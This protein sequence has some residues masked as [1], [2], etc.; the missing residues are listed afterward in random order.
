MILFMQAVWVWGSGED[1]RFKHLANADGLSQGA[2]T[3]MIQDRKGFMWFG[4]Q[5]GLN[6]YDGYKFK[7][8]IR[9]LGEKNTISDNYIWCLFEDKEGY[10]W[11]GTKS[12]GLNRFDPATETFHDFKHDPQVATS[13][14]NNEVLTI[15]IDFLGSIWIGMRDGVVDK[16]N[17]KTGGFEHYRIPIPNSSEKKEDINFVYKIYE[18]MD[19]VLWIGTEKG[20]YTFDGNSKLIVPKFPET[21]NNKRINTIL[22]DRGG[23][24]WIGTNDDGLYQWR[25]ES[26]DF[27]EYR[28]TSPKPYR[29][30][31]KTIKCIFQ[32]KNGTL[33][34]GTQEGLHRLNPTTSNIELYKHNPDYNYSLGNNDILSIY[35]DNAGLMWFGTYG[36]GVSIYDRDFQRFKLYNTKSNP[37]TGLHNNMVFS[38][39]EN[40]EGILWIGTYRGGLTK[41]DRKKGKNAH[42]LEGK[43]VRCFWEDSNGVLWL[44]TYGDGVII[45][46]PKTGKTVKQ[47]QIKDGL[48]HD[49]VLTIYESTSRVIWMA[50]Y[51]G[52]LNRFNPNGDQLFTSYRHDSKDPESLS[53]DNVRG[54]AEDD[55]GYIWVGT[56]GGGLNRLDIKTGKFKRFMSD[57]N[58]KDSLTSNRTM[59]INIDLKKNF[60][61][62]TDSGGLNR[63]V[64]EENKRFEAFG[65]KNGLPNDAIYSIL[66]DTQGNIW[67]S[68]DKGL[69]RFNLETKT[70]KN[71]DIGD[72]LQGNEFNIGAYFKSDSGE[73]FFGGLNGVSA[74]FP[75]EIKDDPFIPPVMITDFFLLNKSVEITQGKTPLNKSILETEEITLDYEQNMFSFEFAALSY[76]NP[77]KNR[78]KYK[79]DGYD[80]NWIETDAM[81][82]RA[83]YT[84]LPAGI[85]TFMV[86]GSNKDGV[87]N[88]SPKSIKIEVLPPPWKT[89]WA[90]TLYGLAVVLILAV[91]MWSQ[92]RKVVVEKKLSSELDQKV[93]DRTLE[94]N[95]K[96]EALE[97]INQIVRSINT[98]T[99]FVDLLQAV[100]REARI[101]KGVERSAILV[102][103]AEKG[104]FRPEIAMGWDFELLRNV[105]LKKEDAKNRYEVGTEEIYEDIFVAKGVPERA[106][107]DIISSQ[108]NELPKSMLITCIRTDNISQAYFVFSNM[109]DENAFDD[110]DI[111]LLKNLK[112]HIVA[113]FQKT[114]LIQILERRNKELKELSTQLL[115]SEK[116]RTMGTLLAGVA[117]EINN[118]TGSIMLNATFFAKAWK[119]ISAILDR[120]DQ[121][122][123]VI[124]ANLVYRE[125]KEDIEKSIAGLLESSRRIKLLIEE[126]KSLSRKDIP[127][128]IIHI[129][130]VIKSAIHLT[131]NQI[132]KST[133][134]LSIQYGE[135]IPEILGNSQRLVQVF[136]NLIQNAC[137]ALSERTR[138]IIIM[139]RNNQSSNEIMV[140]V[141]D[142][143]V[144]IQP[145]DMN[146]ITDPF[147]TTKRGMGGT[148]LGLSISEKI[149]R[150][151]HQG[152]IVFESIPGK[153]TTVTVYLP[154]K[155]FI[156]DKIHQEE[157]LTL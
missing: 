38:I 105:P 131:Q 77:F 22:A 52:G 74:F 125:S 143:G 6:R 69:S 13:L 137:E 151:E 139:T 80:K 59:T 96:N 23:A 71:F 14:S 152:R 39:Y 82:R 93:K 24:V 133:Q 20:L 109:H 148:G 118:P 117:H 145:Q 100:L 92:H 33:W 113:A 104:E 30:N 94:L 8:Y 138:R 35:Q 57:E 107:S 31:N 34:V 88:V 87:W 75:K 84:N 89:W 144:G 154:L 18:S 135:H 149:I 128:E 73:L 2:V 56:D 53:H 129:N 68:T 47:Y 43:D 90:Y 58:N 130:E 16:F 29:S 79:L 119:D 61:V 44:G 26:N 28:T 42:Y 65:L 91:L 17:P 32:E 108:L 21:F 106:F 95:S 45:F 48:S 116:L 98:E 81:N 9:K 115:E 147:F 19:G 55:S 60:W 142:E 50:T 63:L 49:K 78:Y 120:V 64:D 36:G 11:I 134:E 123:K 54:I 146:H 99:E 101:I 62:G 132:K 127:C 157:E 124:I 85:Y 5:D 86:R 41:F 150:D 15:C 4:T 67:L 66:E 121:D 83:T 76:S 46:D 27:K 112:E 110:Q 70:F 153:G 136:I 7:I 103:D 37:P 3:C 126:L 72:G 10:I 122:Q 114:R 140:Q 102:W 156:D 97:K 12:G 40:R 25:K 141:K 111:L 51:G 155:P 1:I